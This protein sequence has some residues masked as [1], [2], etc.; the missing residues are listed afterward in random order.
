MS[1]EILAL[2]VIAVVI[3]LLVVLRKNPYV[4]RYWKY[5]LVLLPL[6]V[7]IVLKIIMDIKNRG[8]LGTDDDEVSGL[9]NKITEIKEDMHDVQMETA[10][11]I[12][13]AKTKNEEVL[14][15]LEEVKNIPD[16]QERRRR[17]AD[18]IG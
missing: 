2:S 6:V 1:W 4:R 11:E 18:M 14:K 10:I 12:S 5:S 13:A 16:K 15:T 7:L 17:L 8:K 9:Q 3:V